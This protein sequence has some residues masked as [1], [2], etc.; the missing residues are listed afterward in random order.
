MSKTAYSSRKIHHCHLE[1]GIPALPNGEAAYYL[2]WY[3]NIPMGHLWL[4]SIYPKDLTEWESFIINSLKQAWSFY[5]KPLNVSEKHQLLRAF[6]DNPTYLNEQ[7]SSNYKKIFQR[8][9]PTTSLPSISVVIC[10]RNRTSA[11]RECLTR[12]F[13]ST[14]KNFEIVVVDNAPSDNG[15]AELIK[16]EFPSVT[17]VLEPRKGLDIA[18]NTGALTAKA[19]I[20]AYTDDDVIV[21]PE[22]VSQI[23]QSFEDPLTMSV[24]GLVIPYRLDTEAQCFFER[25]WGFNK[26]HQPLIFDKAYFA[27]HLPVGVPA[28]DVGA[29]ANMAFRKTV[30]EKV[31]YFDERLDVGASG[32]SGDSEYWY[33]IMAEGFTCRYFPH[34]Y[35]YH[36]HRES[37]DDLKKQI[38]AYMRGNV[39]SVLVQYQ[40]Y[41]HQG[42]LYRLRKS[43]PLY[44]LKRIK[45]A[46]LHPKSRHNKFILEEIKGCFSGWKFFLK[47]KDSPFYPEI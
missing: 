33:R 43:L 47:H 16:K 6:K 17:Y 25:F 15:T 24:T 18:R 26:G 28:W 13:L 44:Y 14:E 4:D 41:H 27:K 19:E 11:L 42:E 34:I 40:K 23:R 7:F 21:T 10:T 35:V 31:G 1:E 3:N 45:F 8:P 38:F 12:L 37:W 39:S 46:I 30:F 5:F 32:C 9:T 20:L 2:F 22:W 36:Q 29:G